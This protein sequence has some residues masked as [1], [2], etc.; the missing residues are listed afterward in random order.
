MSE[1]R[2]LLFDLMLLLLGLTALTLGICVGS[3]DF[4][5]LL[6][7]LLHSKTDPTTILEKLRE[8]SS[9]V[10]VCL[11]GRHCPLEIIELAD[12]VS[13]LKKLQIPA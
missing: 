1:K 10:H 11:T 3:T 6:Q 4:D 9:H 13:D 7:P 12:T 2:S 8:R 5:H